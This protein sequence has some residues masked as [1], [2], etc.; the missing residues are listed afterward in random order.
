MGLVLAEDKF[1]VMGRM[2]SGI[3][4]EELERGMA[5]VEPLAD[6]QDNA[7][8]EALGLGSLEHSS[9]L[10]QASWL[11]LGIEKLVVHTHCT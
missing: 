8:G 1:G 7:E 3:V 4:G 9:Y 6:E 11:D 2:S 10:W 5:L